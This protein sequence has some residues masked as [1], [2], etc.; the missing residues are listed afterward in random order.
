MLISGRLLNH[1]RADP[2]SELGN[3]N[4]E[5]VKKT[6]EETKPGK[7]QRSKDN[8]LKFRSLAGLKIQTLSLILCFEPMD[9]AIYFCV[10]VLGMILG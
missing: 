8:S 3:I 2:M 7:V 10:D 9:L 6:S 5:Y 1:R 4:E